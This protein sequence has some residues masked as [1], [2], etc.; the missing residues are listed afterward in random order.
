MLITPSYLDLQ[1]QL[2]ANYDYGKGVDAQECATIIQGLNAQ[3][4]VDYGCGQGHLARLLSKFEVE[5]YDPCIEGKDEEPARADVVVCAD[6]MEHIEPEC[7]DEVLLHIRAL[8]KKFALFVIATGPSRKV[9]AD[10]RPAHLIV[11]DA[12]FWFQKL[13]GLFNFERFED[14]SH[15]G[16]GLL[17]LCTPRPLPVGVVLPIG[18]IKAISAVDN[19][20]RNANVR[21]NCEI[22]DRRLSIDIPAHDRVAHLACF[23]PSLRKSW[24]LL[25][26]AQANGED[27]F[28]VSGSHDFLRSNGVRPVAHMDCDPRP[29]KVAM[30]TMPDH[31]ISYWLASCVDPAYLEKLAGYEVFLWHSYNGEESTSIIGEIEPQSKMIVGGGSIGLRAMSLLYCRGYRNFQIHGMDCSFDDGEHHAGHHLGKNAEAVQVQCGDRWFSANPVMLTYARY[32]HKQL[33]LMKGATISLHGDGLLQHMV[34]LGV[35]DGL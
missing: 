6:V 5:E 13:A 14:R 32:F 28:S 3:S 21:A 26:I 35:T 33:A 25:A 7:L 12:G 17:I 1:K 19:T 30:L 20:I 27:V 31:R 23:G 34:K 24:P 16:R 18:R 4:A 11:E 8:T 22:N 15:E 9:M 10:G 2:H 29:H